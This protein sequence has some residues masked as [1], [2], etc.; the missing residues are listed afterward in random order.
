MKF[1]DRTFKLTTTVEAEI[2][3]PITK[4]ESQTLRIMHISEKLKVL[5][6]AFRA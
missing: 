6:P 5:F 2:I 3:I 4:N 1:T